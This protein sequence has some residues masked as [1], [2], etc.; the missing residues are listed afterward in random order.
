MRVRL[1]QSRGGRGNNGGRCA[2]GRRIMSA[3]D[4]MSRATRGVQ[5]IL[6]QRLE[7]AVEL[8]A[9]G[10]L[11]DERVHAARKEI[12]KA[13]AML[14]LLRDA[15]SDAMYRR[16]N[17]ALRDCARPLSAV[18]DAKVLL[19]T[20]DALA[21]TVDARGRLRMRDLRR[22]LSAGRPRSLRV[23]SAST[24]AR[25]CSALREC[26]QRSALWNTR[27]AD[28]APIGKGLRRTYRCGRR[29]YAAVLAEG[30]DEEL[31]EWRKQVTHLW[32]QLELLEPIASRS[33]RKL[34]RRAHKL[35]DLLGDDHDLLVLRSTLTAHDRGLAQGDIVA[36][37]RGPIDRRRARLQRKALAVGQAIFAARPRELTKCLGRTWRKW[38]TSGKSM[39]P[40]A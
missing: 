16:E 14:R 30:T 24:I 10:R 4:P 2:R 33:I 20:L 32:R 26:Q 5:R 25:V 9:R 11:N 37:V 29:A 1:P 7:R 19:E 6:H 40:R 12:K 17:V 27:D 15:V 21:E 31:H 28:W 34:T 8:L 22:A 13:R 18:R 23:V 3:C 38:R 35:S 39:A 36:Y